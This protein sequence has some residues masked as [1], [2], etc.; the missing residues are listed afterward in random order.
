MKV[1]WNI[2]TKRKFLII[3]VVSLVNIG[4]NVLLID[5]EAL[6]Y[7]SCFCYAIA[8]TVGLN[9]YRILILGLDLN[10]RDVRL[11]KLV[12]H[13]IELQVFRWFHLSRQ[14]RLDLPY[15][16]QA[17]FIIERQLLRLDK[18]TH[19]SLSLSWWL[20]DRW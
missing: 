10:W 3:I 20:R 8:Y 17:T 5:G 9:F 16:G 1:K 19:S 14:Q 13:N 12:L 15:R 18:F 6:L 11:E 4:F 2:F 7:F